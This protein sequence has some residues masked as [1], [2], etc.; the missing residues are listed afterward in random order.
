MQFALG[1]MKAAMPSVRAQVAIYEKSLLIKN[2]THLTKPRLLELGFSLSEEKDY[3]E[4]DIFEI[5]TVSREYPFTLRIVL[6][7]YPITN[8]NCGI[9]SV[10]DPAH[11]VS[12]VPDDLI[13]KDEWTEE[14]QERAMNYTIHMEAWTQPIAWYVH[15][16]ERLLSICKA[17][18]GDTEYD[19]LFTK[20]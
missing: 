5:K 9:V 14:D 13:H 3:I 8:P 10:H 12:A 1:Q 11:D 15:T 17:L 7:D 19:T 16:E 20:L 4:R 18:F 6:G 2:M